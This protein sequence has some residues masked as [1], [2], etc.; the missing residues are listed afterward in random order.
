M[1]DLFPEV[2][3]K[4]R[5]PGRRGLS[6]LGAALDVILFYI[7]QYHGGGGRE[8]IRRE[9][10]TQVRV[11]RKSNQPNPNYPSKNQQG[12]EMVGLG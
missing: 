6:S 9:C 11:G 12:G 3:A 7:C 2:F 4:M 1:K 8:I 10:G 5:S